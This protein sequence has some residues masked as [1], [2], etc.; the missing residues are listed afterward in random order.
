M[1]VF[2]YMYSGF[3]NA[4]ACLPC[5]KDVCAGVGPSAKREMVYCC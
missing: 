2:H 3:I 4:A 5:G 1:G